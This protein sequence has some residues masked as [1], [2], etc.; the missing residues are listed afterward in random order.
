M[1]TLT[2]NYTVHGPMEVHPLGDDL[3]AV[4]F[5]ASKNLPD[6]VPAPLVWRVSGADLADLAVKIRRASD[7]AKALLATPASKAKN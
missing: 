6:A 1:D 4:V 5:A 2:E 7:L 3:F